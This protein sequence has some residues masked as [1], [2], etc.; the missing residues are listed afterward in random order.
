[1]AE[2]IETSPTAVV[3]GVV[4]TIHAPNETLKALDA[5]ARARGTKLHVVGDVA[6]P[7]TW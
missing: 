6:T 3:G 5:F 1:M 7:E 2:L 4:T